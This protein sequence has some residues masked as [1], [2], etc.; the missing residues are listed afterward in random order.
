MKTEEQFALTPYQPETAAITPMQVIQ[1][2][3]E[4]GQD[5]ATIERLVELQMRMLDYDQK[6]AERR[7]ERDFNDAMKSAQAKMRRIA[8]NAA[9]PQTHSRYVTLDKL[10][11]AIRPIYTA[12]GFSVSFNTEPGAIPEMLRV[13][14]VV[15]HSSGHSRTYHID[16][17]ADGKGA[18]GGDVMTRTHA[19]GSAISYGRR[20][21]SAMIW[22]LSFGGTDDDGNA[23]AAQ[24]RMPESALSDWLANIEAAADIPELQKSYLDAYNAAKAEGDKRAIIAA[25]NARYKQLVKVVAQ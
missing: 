15:S 9:N 11:E 22:N 21:L 24:P 23:A 17:P 14:G 25:K 16:M 10:E 13:V 4:K 6:M 5:I 7:A 3:I 2:A 19:T 12:E 8:P 20:Y 1:Q 18:K